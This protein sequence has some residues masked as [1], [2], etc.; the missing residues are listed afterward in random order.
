M[1]LYTKELQNELQNCGKMPMFEI[2]ILNTDG[3]KDWVIVDVVFE[4]D[5]CIGQRD[6]VSKNE[7]KSKNIARS[8]IAVDDCYGLDEHL[9][10]LHSQV[11]EDICNGDLFTL[12]EE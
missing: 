5:Y 11:I 7:R 4:G 1:K 2:P 10:K 8:K 9:Q 12:A 6:P 3:E